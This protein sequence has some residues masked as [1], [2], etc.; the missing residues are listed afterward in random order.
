MMD[1]FTDGDI[2]KP[3]DL[4]AVGRLDRPEQIAEAVPRMA[5]DRGGFVTGSAVVVG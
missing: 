1:G 4:E 5:S 2:R 3:V